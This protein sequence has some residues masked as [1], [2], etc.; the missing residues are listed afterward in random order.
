MASFKGNF[1][2]AG[3]LVTFRDRT[4]SIES[5]ATKFAQ[6]FAPGYYYLGNEIVNA[7]D[8]DEL[9]KMHTTMSSIASPHPIEDYN[10]LN[11]KENERLQNMRETEISQ[12]EMIQTMMRNAYNRRD[13]ENAAAERAKNAQLQ[14]MRET[15]IL[16][17]EARQ[18]MVRNADNRRKEEEAAADRTK[19]VQLQKD[20]D[21]ALARSIAVIKATEAKGLS[22]TGGKSHRVR[23]QN[24]SKNRR[25][26]KSKKAKRSRR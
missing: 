14:E 1:Y 10:K 11:Q 22:V 9:A 20:E 5:V 7:V 23:K 19:N 15:A 16:Q 8:P 24:K 12:N 6:Y 17:N 18:T 4:G 21:A 3:T 26:K 2:P 25:T 13:E